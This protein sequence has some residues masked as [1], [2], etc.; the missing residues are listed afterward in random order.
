MTQEHQTRRGVVLYETSPFMPSVQTRTRRVTNKRGDMMLISNEGEIQSQIAGFWEAKQVDATKFVKLFVNGV[1]ALAELTSAGTRVFE[2]LYL[3]MQKTPNKDTVYLS[4]TGLDKNEKAISRSTFTRGISELVEK[5]F[6]ASM[7][8][9]GWYWV[10]PDFVW[11]GDRLRFVQEYTKAPSRPRSEEKDTRTLDLFEA[12][13][14]ALPA[15]EAQN[16]A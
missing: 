7:P 6:I 2:L 16:E 14:E 12:T 3:E 11:N 15:P 5:Q 4:F 1:K 9:V 8:A 10:N 13:P